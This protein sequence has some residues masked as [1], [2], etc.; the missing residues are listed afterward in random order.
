MKNRTRNHLNLIWSSTFDK[1]VMKIQS[2][3]RF[4][5]RLLSRSLSFEGSSKIS[6]FPSYSRKIDSSHCLFF[7]FSDG[8]IPTFRDRNHSLKFPNLK[9][10]SKTWWHL[11]CKIQYL[12]AANGGGRGRRGGGVRDARQGKEWE[13]E[14]GEVDKFGFTFPS[15][16]PQRRKSLQT[17]YCCNHCRCY[18]KFKTTM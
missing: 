4:H 18:C 7:W 10:S 2:L 9:L 8:F 11:F 5:E 3:Q 1:E 17:I 12:K 14:E 13:E 6:S 15:H 16:L